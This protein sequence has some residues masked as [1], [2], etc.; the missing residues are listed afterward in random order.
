MDKTKLTAT[1]IN[2]NT[3][4]V[5]GSTAAPLKQTSTH[6]LTVSHAFLAALLTPLVLSMKATLASN[7][8]DYNYRCTT[9]YYYS[10]YLEAIYYSAHCPYFCPVSEYCC[11]SQSLV[12]TLI[13]YSLNQ[14]SPKYTLSLATK[15]S[16]NCI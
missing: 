9:I 16:L 4:T 1:C 14:I 10:E 7:S 2:F 12:L 3:S 6:K 13:H 8:E 11:F 15:L 5:Q